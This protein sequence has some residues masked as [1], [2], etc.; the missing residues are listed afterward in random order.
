MR[1]SV[2]P[3]ISS[4]PSPWPWVSSCRRTYPMVI[5]TWVPMPKPGDVRASTIETCASVLVDQAC[6]LLSQIRPLR[7]RV[8]PLL[9]RCPGHGSRVLSGG[10]CISVCT[11]N[12][13][14]MSATIIKVIREDVPTR[15]FCLEFCTGSSLSLSDRRNAQ[16]SHKKG[17]CKCCDLHDF[18]ALIWYRIW[19]A[20][21]A[22]RS[23]A[24]STRIPGSELVLGNR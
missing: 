6:C 12:L 5:G 1:I 17:S 19:E 21:S 4:G 9:S 24:L 16:Q 20:N 18:L 8:G 7:Y 11:T 23:G 14:E 13:Y 15:Y 2:W 3:T 22:C 10:S